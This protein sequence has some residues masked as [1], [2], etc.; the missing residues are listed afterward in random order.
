[1]EPGTNVTYMYTVEA[2]ASTWEQNERKER[3]KRVSFQVTN[4]H[5]KNR[6]IPG[7]ARTAVMIYN[8]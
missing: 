4:L 7:T 2:D 6:I 1:M 3:I 5:R 8:Y